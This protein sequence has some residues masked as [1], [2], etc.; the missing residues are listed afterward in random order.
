[1]STHRE[2]VPRALVDEYVARGW[3][4]HD[5]LTDCIRRNRRHDEDGLA[6]ASEDERMSW[7]EYDET[8]DR[9][10]A[11]LMQA[12][13]EPGDRVAV[14]LEDGPLIHA[15]FVGGERA[16]VVV[17]GVGAKAGDRE[18]HHILTKTGARAVLAP[19]VHRGV[20]TDDR[21]AALGIEGLRAISIEALPEPTAAELA[22]IEDRRV[23]PNDLFLLNTT[24]GTTGLPKCVTQF[25]NRWFFYEKL[26]S[27]SGALTGDDVFMS[28]V[29]APFGFGL[30]TSHF[31]PT[32]LGCP[33]VVMRRFSPEGALALIE[34]ERVSVLSAVSTQFMMMLNSPDVAET[35]FTSLRALYTGGEAV[36]YERAA[37]FEERTGAVVLQFFGSNETGGFSG[38][39]IDDTR[40]QRL[41]TAGRILPEMDVRLFDDDGHDVTASG[42][43]AVP[44]GKGPALCAGYYDDDEAN[45]QL[46]NADGYMLMGDYVT[47]DDEGYLAVVGRKSDFIIR[48]GKNISAPQVEA[49]VAAHP[50][51]DL[52][53]A[54][55]APDPVFGERVCAVVTVREGSTLELAELCEFLGA[56]G[57][58]KELFPEYL[59][60]VDEMPTA[61]GGK[62]GKGAL[63]DRVAEIVASAQTSIG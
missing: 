16:G 24:S 40:E 19:E 11:R 38:T 30:W 42:G 14:L 54:I 56:R 36:P 12:G 15:A 34:R 13:L 61:S 4:G 52:A 44:G 55:A 18:L 28:V 58:S 5:T 59:A 7:R 6:F 25:Q 17:V 2:I 53:A 63:K 23:G 29:P 39:S 45:A 62:I 21:V 41:T 9:I 22:T 48:G 26:A 31:V 60:V 27:R 47:V 33:T 51:V 43:P 20:R 37:E 57:V 50:V 49:E 32:I 46:Y 8:A 10:A 3:W 1:M 35:D